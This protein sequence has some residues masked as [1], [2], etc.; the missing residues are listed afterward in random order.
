MKIRRL[1]AEL[2]KGQTDRRTDGHT[3]RY[4]EANISFS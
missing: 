4:V 2:T 3:D 1:E